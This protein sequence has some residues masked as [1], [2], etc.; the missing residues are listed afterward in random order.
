M[1]LHRALIIL[2][3]LASATNVALAT[4]SNLTTIKEIRDQESCDPSS[5]VAVIAYLHSSRHGA[6]ISDGYG[7]AI[8][9]ASSLDP[10]SN[11]DFFRYL[12]DPKLYMNNRFKARFVGH[13]SCD[14]RGAHKFVVEQVESISISRRRYAN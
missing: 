14:E 8:E 6:R 10:A 13:V 7:I 12:Y 3:I 2:L 5:A 4:E 9:I 11:K 1:N